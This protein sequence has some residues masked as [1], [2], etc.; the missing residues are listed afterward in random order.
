MEKRWTWFKGLYGWAVFNNYTKTISHYEETMIDAI[1][2]C[3][4]WNKEKREF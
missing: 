2:C 3:N 1:R 4:Q